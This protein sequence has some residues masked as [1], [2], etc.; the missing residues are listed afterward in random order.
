MKIGNFCG[1]H[2]PHLVYEFVAFAEGFK[3]AAEKFRVESGTSPTI[4]LATL[5]KRILI[6]NHIQSGEIEKAI[7]LINELHPELLDNDNALYFLL[8]V[9]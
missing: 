7:I 8:Q 6:R 9:G 5:D 1:T 2:A 4:D 3:E